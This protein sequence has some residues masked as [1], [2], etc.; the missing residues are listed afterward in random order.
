MKYPLMQGLDSRIFQSMSQMTRTK[1]IT[2]AIL[3]WV[4]CAVRPLNVE[5]LSEALTLDFGDM[6]VSVERTIASLC[7]SFIY[8]DANKVVQ[9]VHDSVKTF[10][11]RGAFDSEFTI[12]EKEANGKLATVC[13]EYLTEDFMSS[14]M[15][16]PRR[17]NLRVSHLGKRVFLG[18][19]SKYFSEH[20]PKASE[21]FREPLIL[22]VH[23]MLQAL[24]AGNLVLTRTGGI[25]A[26]F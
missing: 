12:N 22:Q 10:I 9:P 17:K 23:R 1:P 14:V 21:V 15:Q 7:G 25:L 16:K 8:V 4:S 3:M 2:K 20:S 11:L 13:L 26:A 5:E 19:G 18:Y 24:R 6:L